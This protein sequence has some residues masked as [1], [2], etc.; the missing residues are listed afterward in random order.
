MEFE[1]LGFLRMKEA[2]QSE[3]FENDL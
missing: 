2:S 1:E 3:K